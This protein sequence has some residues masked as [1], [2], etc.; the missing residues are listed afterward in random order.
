MTRIDLQLEYRFDT[1]EY[2]ESDADYAVW[3]EEQLLYIRN[4][5][6]IVDND[7]LVGMK[8]FDARM[9]DIKQTIKLTTRSKI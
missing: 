4:R 6:S 5:L 3:L 2:P 7:I 9:E 1:G 8:R